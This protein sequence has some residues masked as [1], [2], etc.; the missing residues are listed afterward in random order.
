MRKCFG[1]LFAALALYILLPVFGGVVHI[2]IWVGALCFGLPALYWLKPNWFRWLTERRKLHRVVQIVFALGVTAALTISALMA[3]A[4]YR[5]PP[6]DDEKPV[7]VVVLGC[8]VIDGRPS[9]TLRGRIKAAYEYLTDHPAALCVASGGMDD[10]EAKTEADCIAD[11]LIAMGI[12][13]GRIYRETAS[14]NTAENLQFSTAVIRET[15]L[16][17]TVVIATDRFHEFRGEFFAKQNGLTPYAAGCGSPW[18]LLGGFWVREV[19]AIGG[20]LIR[21]Y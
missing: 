5:V 6:T 1:W 12:D 8:Q 13:A 15:R 18:Y 21:G 11:T 16:P 17:D 2:G 20:M 3:C 10:G 9:V 4:A 14:T 7:T 19:M